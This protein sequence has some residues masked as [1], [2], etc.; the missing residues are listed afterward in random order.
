M[1]L[2]QA[3]YEGLGWAPIDKLKRIALDKQV[4]LHNREQEEV[5]NKRVYSE[6]RLHRRQLYRH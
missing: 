1:I 4:E 3:F 5:I 6:L 2:V